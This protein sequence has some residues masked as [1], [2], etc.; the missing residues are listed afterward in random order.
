MKKLDILIIKSFLGP[1]LL[2][3]SISEFVLLLQ[4]IWKILERMIGK[5]LDTL[6]ILQLFW[7]ILVTLVPMALPLAI[8][9][10]SIMTLGNFG[11]RY[12]LVAMKSA[13]ISLWRILKPLIVVVAFLSVFAFFFSNNFM[14]IAEKKMRTL[15]YE[16]NTK[17]PTVNIRPNEFYADIEQY[18]IRVGAKDKE[19]KNLTDVV[20]YDHS[21][22]V[23][24]ISITVAKKGQ[25]YSEDDGNTLVFN[26]IDGYTYD[27]SVDDQSID[28]R[29]L[30]RLNFKE[31]LI[32]FD[33]SD[34]A[35][36][37]T[38]EDRY[39]NH[40]KMLNISQLNRNIGELRKENSDFNKS[41]V[42]GIKNQ[43]TSPIIRDSNIIRMDSLYEF[44]FYKDFKALSK[45]DNQKIINQASQK[46]Q[47]LQN[48]MKMLDSKRNG[49][50][51]LIIRHRNELHRK[52]T[53]SAA[54][55]ILFFIGAPLG[56]II[57][58]G[59]LGMPVVV[60]VLSFILYYVVGMIGEKASVEG[61]VSSFLGM[62]SSTLVFLPI[63]IFLTIKATS[64]SALLNPESWIKA[65][66][67]IKNF[68][69]GH[70]IKNK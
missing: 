34:F 67:K 38:D 21:K 12:E 63:G 15:M 32:R 53:L 3:F 27:E 5:G 17:K 36:K 49:D 18:I 1:L 61:A 62:W 10:A 16:I 24:N 23:G 30:V 64:D 56:A 48:D 14:P 6:V 39:N 35:F 43:I 66:N 59:G 55:L 41:I 44:S 26:L 28:T 19:G 11:E 7:Y 20:I 69:T 31:Q 42:S 40:Y 58:K 13:G 50:S 68:L 65:M 4:F 60:S 22:S 57:R 9:L 46:T 2:T 8:L 45:E 33:V 51:E 37:E 25:M 29:P 54:C 52:F 47:Y 70:K